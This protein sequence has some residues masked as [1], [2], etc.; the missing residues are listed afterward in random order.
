[1]D[2]ILVLTR[3]SKLSAS[4]VLLSNLIHRIFVCRQV[5]AWRMFYGSTSGM[6]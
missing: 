6:L 4:V 3:K 2:D 5:S 1:M